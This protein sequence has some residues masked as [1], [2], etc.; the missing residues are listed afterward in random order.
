ML[1]RV[2][3]II[4]SSLNGM[5]Q[6]ALLP[7]RTEINQKDACGNSDESPTRN[8][9]QV[10]DEDFISCAAVL[11][12]FLETVQTQGIKCCAKNECDP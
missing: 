11:C 12:T 5:D 1:G 4:I 9:G 6:L 2:S 8:Y 3:Q 7:V 10:Y